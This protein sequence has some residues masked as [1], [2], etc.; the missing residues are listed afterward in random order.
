MKEN[1]EKAAEKPHIRDATSTLQQNP[2]WLENPF[3]S[4]SNLPHTTFSA[5]SAEL[6]PVGIRI[7]KETFTPFPAT[8][9]AEAGSPFYPSLVSNSSKVE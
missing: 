8:S 4:T 1:E 6:E 9:E 2:I 7:R 5:F 3:Q